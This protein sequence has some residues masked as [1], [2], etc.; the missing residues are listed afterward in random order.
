[1]SLVARALETNGI[2]T[3][4]LGSA[5]DIME[6]CGA[7]RFVF[8]DFPLG[9]PCGRP[10]DTKSQQLI[11]DNALEALASAEKPGQC[12]NSGLHWSS[13]SDWKRQYMYVGPEN[14]EALKL[15]GEQRRKKREALRNRIGK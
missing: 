6:F 14:E 2:A 15:A 8:T 4:V 5:K 11:M 12:F 7:P 10:D 9:N 3:V 1:M 13:D